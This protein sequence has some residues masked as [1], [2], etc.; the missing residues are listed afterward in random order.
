MLDEQSKAELGRVL[1]ERGYLVM[2]SPNCHVLGEPLHGVTLGQE[3]FDQPVCVI[4]ET[5]YEDWLQQQ[6]LVN[7]WADGRY[8]LPGNRFY[9]IS[10]D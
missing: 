3:P 7:T 9:R 1:S 6:A 8:G 2:V 5:T 4:S 10:V